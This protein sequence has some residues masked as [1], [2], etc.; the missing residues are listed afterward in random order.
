MSLWRQL[1]RGVRVLAN[2]TAA[3][4]DV[5][6]EVEHYLDEATA[7]YEA[8]GLSTEE[9]RRAA[10]RHVGSPALVREQVRSYGWENA[11]ETLAADLRYG[12]RQLRSDPGF[13]AV[14]VITL[15]L[16]I[17]AIT[18]IF[19]AVK[20]VLIDSLPYPHAERLVAIWDTDRDR[21]RADVTFGTYRELV[22]RTRSFD[23]L[24][25]L[26]PWQPSLTGAAQPERLDGQRV[27]APYFRVLGVRPVLGRDF[28]PSDDRVNGPNVVILS[29]GL[30]RRRFGADPTIVGR[31]VTLDDDAFVVVGVM[32]ATFENVLAPSCEAWSLLQYDDS[33]PRDGREWGH[34]LRMVGRLRPGVA[35]SQAAQEL[36]AIAHSGVEQFSRPLWAS[37][38]S[39]LLVR[40]LHDDVTRG[41]EA[42]LTAVI[43]AVLLLLAIACVNVTNLLLARGAERRGEFAMRAALGAVRGRLVQQLLTESLLLAGLGGLGGLMVASLGIRA[44]VALSPPGL[45]RTGAMAID[46]AIFIFACGI[47]TMVGVVIGVVPAVHALRND[48]HPRVEHASQRMVAGHQWARRSLVVAQVAIALILMVS[49]GLLLR[50]V[51]RLLAI[52]PGFAAAHVLTMQVQASGHRF[53]DDRS[54]EQFFTNALEAVRG[55]AGVS[56]AAFTSQLPLS[57]DVD[58]YG[59]HLESV[60]E[61]ASSDD[62]SAFRYAV[63]PGYFQAMGI[64]LRRGR[65]LDARDIAGAPPAVVIGE[66]LARRRFAGRDAIGQRLH[67][68]PTDRPWFT[69]VGIVADVRQTSLAIGQAEAVY[70]TNAH[71]HFADRAR[72]LTVRAKGDPAALTT[73]VRNAIWGIDKDQ[74]IVRVATMEHLVAASEAQRRFALTLFETFGVVA[75]VLAAA[76]IYGLLSGSVTERTR[77]IGVRAAL[78]A[79]PG[80]ILELVLRQGMTPA[81]FGVAIGVTA[82]ALVSRG[83]TTLLYGISALDP[84]SYLSGTVVLLAVAAI[85]CGIPARRAAAIDPAVT[86]RS[87]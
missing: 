15:A 75:L 24:S 51:Q 61:N 40:S 6:D 23:A 2:R 18:A 53:D 34:H 3:D 50:S 36:D 1:S 43:G 58:L 78:G 66:S 29:D 49:A 73:S 26:K 59:V 74:P 80:D 5:A 22:E 76:G 7:A 71:S 65:L 48:L 27:S 30:W 31:Q 10:R 47:T 35:T 86:L 64:P 14:G 39:G 70:V 20:P 37:L 85:A 83:L 68:G 17:G 57:G 41:S 72:W 21:S 77:E 54:T 81:A 52:N 55:V 32:P 13:T 33:L 16:G 28:Q 63:S 11:V 12:I 44:I 45:P 4:Q 25:A 69:V 9:A 67:V 38:E 42:A 19:S 82:A 79:S 60:P 84:V 46:G 87:E 62:H 56:A 8:Q